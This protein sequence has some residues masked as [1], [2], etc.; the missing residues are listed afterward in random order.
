MG[1]PAGA[2][3]YGAVACCSAVD[4]CLAPAGQRFLFGGTESLAELQ[5]V[6]LKDHES[7]VMSSE[8]RLI[9]GWFLGS[10]ARRR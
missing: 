2:I 4:D 7:E 8:D 5:S 1:L 3:H 10:N 6:Q 9:A